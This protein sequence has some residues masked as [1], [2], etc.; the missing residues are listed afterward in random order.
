MNELQKLLG[1]DLPDEAKGLREKVKSSYTQ[2]SDANVNFKNSV[3]SKDNAISEMTEQ[4]NGFKTQIANLKEEVANGG[5]KDNSEAIEAVRKA[6][7]TK[8]LE[9]E[10][11]YKGLQAKNQE[12]SR[13]NQFN[14]L[15]I[16]S[17]FPKD[18]DEKQVDFAKKAIQREVLDG[19][20]Y[21]DESQAWG[22]KDALKYDGQTGSP[23][24]I[25]GRYKSMEA[26]GAFDMF[27]TGKQG[28]GGGTPPN[29]VNS[30]GGAKKFSDY[31]AQELV[32]IKNSNP[33][34]YERLRE[35][36]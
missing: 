12:T 28:S 22:Y 20:V 5:N 2:L 34:E 31:N 1:M 16:A 35:T 14:G 27:F 33:A 6:G 21:D 17:N 32:E 30:G 8:Y 9:L 4:R 18:W 24:T 7:D 11:R 29:T 26:S 23:L 15:N 25:E 19:S 13:L 10:E 36:R 3:E